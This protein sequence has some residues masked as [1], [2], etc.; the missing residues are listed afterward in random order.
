M[1]VKLAGKVILGLAVLF[2][3]IQAIPYGHDH[4]NPP[5]RAEPA[6]DS[7]QTRELVV[8]ACYDCHSNE[9][10]WPW[11]ANIAPL[12]WLIE[13]DVKGGR[14]EL[15]FS[16]WDRWRGEGGEA[17]KTVRKGEMPP[18]LYILLQPKARLSPAEREALIRGLE[19]TLGV[20]TEREE[21]DD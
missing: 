21:D 2:L 6:W 12:S 17:A 16:E 7:P 19:A 1:V 11:Y 4:S 8:R 9:T 15:N 13:N 20:S 18:L 3:L 10:V 14:H 5:V